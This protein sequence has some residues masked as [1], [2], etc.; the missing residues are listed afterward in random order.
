MKYASKGN[1][2]FEIQMKHLKWYTPEIGN[3]VKVNRLA[4]QN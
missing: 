1:A 4:R 2:V 3:S